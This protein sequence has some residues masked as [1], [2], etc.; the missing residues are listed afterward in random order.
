MFLTDSAIPA[1]MLMK[2]IDKTFKHHINYFIALT[3]Y[4]SIIQTV[5]HRSRAKSRLCSSATLQ[6]KAR[7]DLDLVQRLRMR[8]G[9]MADGPQYLAA[10]N[11][12]DCGK[13]AVVVLGLAFSRRFHGLYTVNV[14]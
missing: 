9:Y 4:R 1:L 11:A 8:S 10:A 14:R 12:A 3:Y 5:L 13:L 2:A 7:E 6:T